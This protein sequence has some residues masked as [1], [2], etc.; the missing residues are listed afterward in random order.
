MPPQYSDLGRIR[1]RQL[2]P[3]GQP[4]RHGVAKHQDRGGHGTFGLGIGF[5]RRRRLGIIY[6]RRRSLR[7]VLLL[8]QLRGWFEPVERSTLPAGLGRAIF[9][10]LGAGGGRG[11]GGER[12]YP[13]WFFNGKSRGGSKAPKK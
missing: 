8:L 13:N 6:R 2:E 11:R 10:K 3:I 4:V 12:H 1:I 5:L 7:L 9:K